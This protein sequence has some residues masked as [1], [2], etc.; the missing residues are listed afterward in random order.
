MASAQNETK[1]L[2][3]HQ[4]IARQIGIAILSGEI[5]PGGALDGEIEQS[6]A[7][8]VSRTA[9]REAIR[10]LIAK[11]LLESRPKA[12]TH[13]TPRARWSMLDP[14]VLG[15][16]FSGKPNER[17]IHELFE[18]RGVIEPAAAA[19]AARRRTDAQLTSMR[20]GL[21]AMRVH[22]LATAEGRDGDRQFHS[23]ILEATANEP[24]ASLSS[25][26]SAAVTWTT[27]F[28]QRGGSVPRDPLGEHLALYKA[29]EAGDAEAARRAMEHLLRLALDDMGVSSD[30]S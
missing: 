6:E 5:Q 16:M 3:I 14:D 13:V 19:L 4:T 26:V 20:E 17:F 21:E 24:L 2:R 29:I 22:T 12:G 23:A 30:R 1:G 27:H 11:G 10:I 18:L 9:Y 15:W 28:K 8:H 7:L 25:S